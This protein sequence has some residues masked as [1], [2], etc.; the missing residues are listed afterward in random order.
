MAKK[1]LEVI[2][3]GKCGGKTVKNEVRSSVLLSQTYEA[4]RFVHIK[5]PVYSADND[6]LIVVRHPIERVKYFGLQ[7][8]L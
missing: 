4:I 6:Y 1:T 8:A 7:L 2:H 3:I 5:R